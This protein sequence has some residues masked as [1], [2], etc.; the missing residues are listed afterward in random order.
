MNAHSKWAASA[1]GR[2]MVCPGNIALQEG[3]PKMPSGYPAKWG[4]A[5]HELVAKVLQ[6]GVKVETFLDSTFTVEGEE[7]TVDDAMIECAQLYLDYIDERR[8]QGFELIGVEIKFDLAPLGATMEAGGTADCVLYHPVLEELE[9]LDLKTGKGVLVEVAGNAQTRLYMIGVMT[10]FPKLRVKR[11]RSTIVQPR[12]A[13]RDGRIRSEDISTVDMLDWA[14]DLVESINKAQAALEAYHRADR[15]DLIDKW[16]DD[17]LVASDYCTY[18]PAAGGCPKLRKL[19]MATAGAD[20]SENKP[21]FVSNKLSENS[22]AVV[23]RDMD[24][25]PLLE[26]WISGRR[27]LAHK[28]ATDGHK[29]DHHVLVEKVGHRKFDFPSP[30]LTAAAIRSRISISNEQLYEDP[31]LRSPASL[32]RSIGKKTVADRLGDLIVKPVI[33]TDLVSTLGTVNTRRKP[34]QSTSERFFVNK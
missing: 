9:N 16:T 33:G 19:A 21:K 29:F 27:A 1:S 26:E 3:L 20:V 2:N 28:M 13:H 7:F 22:P 15:S 6:Q 10:V 30:E 25:I 17:Y 12:V 31:K 5:C 4:T 32:E 11:F 34:V 18:C 23:E 24:L 8:G 14:M